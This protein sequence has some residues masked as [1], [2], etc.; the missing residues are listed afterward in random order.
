MSEDVYTHRLGEQFQQW[1]VDPEKLQ[2]GDC[3]QS[4]SEES[5]LSKWEL[6]DLV[7]RIQRPG[8]ENSEICSDNS[9]E[10]VERTRSDSDH[11]VRWLL[12]LIDLHNKLKG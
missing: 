1:D 9:D 8:S 7:V 11:T 4:Y 3:E 12:C 2:A 10:A 5:L 6:K